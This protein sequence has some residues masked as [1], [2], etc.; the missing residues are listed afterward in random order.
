[1]TITAP[2]L[3]DTSIAGLHTPVSFLNDHLSWTDIRR[4]GNARL[5]RDHPIAPFPVSDP[6][7]GIDAQA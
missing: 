1:M 7:S 2:E 4:T 3:L 5:H 6:S